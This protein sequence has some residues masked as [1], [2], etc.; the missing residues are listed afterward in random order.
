MFG[1]DSFNNKLTKLAKL[2]TNKLKGA[3]TFQGTVEA[4]FTITHVGGV[5]RLLVFAHRGDCIW[6]MAFGNQLRGNCLDSK[7]K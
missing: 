4:V 1:T 6:K 5:V 3:C 2:R 7:F